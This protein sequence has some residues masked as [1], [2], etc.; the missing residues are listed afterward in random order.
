MN[1]E[2]ETFRTIFFW[3]VYKRDPFLYASV[4][5]LLFPDELE[6]RCSVAKAAILKLCKPFSFNFN[7][8][9]GVDK[10]FEKNLCGGKFQ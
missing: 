9:Q 1:F 6:H 4:A 3:G 7:L 2:L 5:V 8:S 10:I